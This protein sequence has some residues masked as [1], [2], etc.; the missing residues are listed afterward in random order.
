MG[1]IAVGIDKSRSFRFYIGYLK[2]LIEDAAVYHNPSLLS[3]TILGRTL[4]GAALMGAMLKNEEEKL[5]L[6]IRGEGI[7]KEVLAVANGRGKIK[8]YIANPDIDLPNKAD[9]SMNLEG[10]IGIGNLTVI[11]DVGL[12]EPYTGSISLVSG[13]IAEDLAAYFYISEQKNTMVALSESAGVIIQMLPEASEEAIQAIENLS[14]NLKPLKELMRESI[15]VSEFVANVFK[16]IDEEFK[17]IVLEEKECKWECDCSKSR[18]EKALVAT[19]KKTL[20]E[21]AD[22]KDDIETVCNFCGKKYYF[23]PEDIHRIQEDTEDDR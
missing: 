20:E 11:K 3:A 22:S 5:T 4:V 9:G 10:A 16:G 7:A 12:K 13:E 21:L 8:G 2:D 6:A 14:R 18:F 1:H 17:P 23:T 15:D 19:G